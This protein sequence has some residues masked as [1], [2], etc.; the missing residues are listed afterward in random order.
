MKKIQG[1]L[2]NMMVPVSTAIASNDFMQSLS[3]GMMSVLPI[4]MVGAVFSIL[5]NLP[6][7]AYKTFL[8]TSGVSDIF[9]LAVTMT[10]QLIGVFMTFLLPAVS[11][12][13]GA[14]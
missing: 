7:H 6:I 10:T 12:R 3:A 8:S 4:M 5:M 13:H 2:E 11:H 9:N 14:C 1:W